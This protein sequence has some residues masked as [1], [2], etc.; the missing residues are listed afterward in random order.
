MQERSNRIIIKKEIIHWGGC[1][2][3]FLLNN[4][5]KP[6]REIGLAWHMI[7]RSKYLHEMW[8]L[9]GYSSSQPQIIFSSTFHYAWNFTTS[10]PFIV[11]R[12]GVSS[13]LTFKVSN[14][15]RSTLLLVPVIDPISYVSLFYFERGEY[16]CRTNQRTH[17]MF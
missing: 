2:W 8:E 6:F 16:F 10:D 1:R 5:I 14:P 12:Q 4:H 11:S 17:A 9:T 7:E 13:C 15:K 3:R